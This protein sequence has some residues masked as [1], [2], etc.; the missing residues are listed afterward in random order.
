MLSNSS[1]GVSRRNRSEH[2]SACYYLLH[3]LLDVTRL[4]YVTCYR[5]KNI[6]VLGS[7][8]VDLTQRSDH[9]CAS[10]HCGLITPPCRRLNARELQEYRCNVVGRNSSSVDQD[11][12]A[13][14]VVLLVALDVGSERIQRSRRLLRS[15]VEVLRRDTLKVIPASD[16]ELL[17]SSYTH[18]HSQVTLCF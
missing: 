3:W 1:R 15:L 16:I 9:R 10:L 14:R 13:L 4:S 17:Q 18:M 8:W 12:L 2:A 7:T 5:V 11:L 6:C